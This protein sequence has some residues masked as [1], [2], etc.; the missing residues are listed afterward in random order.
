MPELRSR[1]QELALCG[2]TG[3]LDSQYGRIDFRVPAAAEPFILEANANPDPSPQ[4]RWRTPWPLPV[5]RMLIFWC[6]WCGKRWNAHRGQGSGVR[7]QGSGVRGQGSGVR[8]Q[9]SEKQKPIR[10]PTL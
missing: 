9:G 4:R 5:W 1:L 10:F 8:G 7:G 3:V 2:L 6:G